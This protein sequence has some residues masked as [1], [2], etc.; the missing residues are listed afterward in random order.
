MAGVEREH[1]EPVV[2]CRLTFEAGRLHAHLP[3]RDAPVP[4]RIL[5]A[6]PLSARTEV[7]LL[8]DDS[9][10]VLTLPSID[11]LDDDSRATARA[12]L[13]ERYQLACVTRVHRVQ[14]TF[15]TRYFDVETDRGATTFAVREPGKNVTWLTDDHLI[16]RDTMGGRF[17]VPSVGALDAASQRAIRA[18]L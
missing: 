16:V 4:V 11:T 6:R 17:E 13:D 3:D 18:M 8:D 15:G 9:N 12:A 7:V 2:T 5:Y 1:G 14:L 10:E